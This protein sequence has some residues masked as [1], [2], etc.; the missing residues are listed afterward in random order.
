[1]SSSS[2]LISS[3]RPPRSASP[4]RDWFAR[5]FPNGPTPAQSL[6][7]PAIERGDHLLL[8][9]P[10]GNGKTLAAFLAIL[11]R[12][13][14]NPPPDGLR[15]VYLSPLRSLGYDIEKNLNEPLRAIAAA[16]GLERSPIRIGVRT[17]DTTAYARS[18]QREAPPHLLITTPESLA[19]LLSQ[20]NWNG[21]W[22]TVEHVIV[23]EIH[24]LA[25][26]KRGADL[27]VSLERLAACC[28]RDPSRIGLS[29]TCRPTSVIAEFLVGPSRVCSI[30]EA[31]PPPGSPPLEIG[32]EAL[33]EPN[34]AIH[35]G[36]SYRR[37]LNRV[38]QAV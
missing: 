27:M 34:E 25:P 22:R 1:M 7:W 5:A 35:R 9:A 11:D 16:E 13:W 37:L 26:T 8:T 6:A 36:L 4:V 31:P 29:A 20:D 18:K 14:G 23:D 38:R 3:S 30:A 17:G 15:C 28:D 32:V 2:H 24:A 12:L 19:L 21:I 10:T 33:Q